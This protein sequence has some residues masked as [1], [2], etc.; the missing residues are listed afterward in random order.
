MSYYKML[1]AYYKIWKFIRNY[2]QFIT[3]MRTFIAKYCIRDRGINFE[4]GG[5][6][7]TVSDSIL[8][9]HNTFFRTNSL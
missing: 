3:K 1:Q 7:G 2:C 5:G 6:G 4:I 8:G 9:G